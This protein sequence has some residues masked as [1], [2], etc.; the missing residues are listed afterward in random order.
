MHVRNAVRGVPGFTR[1]KGLCHN[2]PMRAQESKYGFDF[3]CRGCGA[4]GP[5]GGQSACAACGEPMSLRALGTLSPG[6]LRRPPRSMWHYFGLLPVTSRKRI[7]TL[8][9]GATPLVDA[10]RLARRFGFGQV[11]VKN[12]M[13]NPTGSF[14]DRQVSV[15][16]SHARECGARTVA[17]VSSGNVA[18]ATS[19]YAAHAG[20]QAVVFMH[21]HAGA[22]KVAQAAAYGARVIRVESPSPKEV[23]GLCIEACQRYGW[24]HLSTAGM[25]EPYNVEGAKTL[26]YELYQ[27]CG[28]H[29]PDWVVMPVGGGGLLGGVWRGFL[30]LKR[31]GLINRVPRLAGVQASGC[32]PL[33][34]AIEHGES[35]LE[36]LRHP[37][38]DPKTVAGGIAD[39]ILF[40][41]HTALPA[42]RET[43]GVVIAVDDEAIIE[44][45][46]TLA[47]EEGLLCELTS[48][49][50]IAALP[51]LP[52]A[53]ASSRVCCVVTG[54]GIKELAW[55]AGRV[56]EPSRIP[57]TMEALAA[58]VEA[59][60]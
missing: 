40:D 20:M 11:I 29:P 57:P 52:D 17:A 7:V 22:G 27:Q 25:Y 2:A 41:G 50:V 24:Y 3:V 15:G 31:L 10:P 9:E 45:Q 8:G 23:F 48:A 37:W 59:Q 5:L 54:S 26:A 36:T 33:K 60:P 21:A 28:G 13:A 53:D 56:P 30:D 12:E 43:N 44:S 4:S 1:A 49:V 39:D 19:A 16:I 35:F 14:K 55:L 51:F 32:A 38:P 58:C 6:Y 18:A 42:I 47:R 46:Q 34:R